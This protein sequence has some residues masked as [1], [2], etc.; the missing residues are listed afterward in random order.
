MKPRCVV[1]INVPTPYRQPMFEAMAL[2]GRVDL[3][4]IYC[5][6]AHIDPSNDGRSNQYGVHFLG[7]AY[8][9]QD[10]RF[11]HADLSVMRLLSELRPDVVVTTGFI[12]TFLFSYF[13]AKLHG[14]RHIAMTDGTLESEGGLSALHRIVRRFVFAGTHAFVGACK[15]SRDLYLSYG[16][17]AERIHLSA[18]CTLNERFQKSQ[19]EKVYDFLFC[20]RYLELKNPLFAISVAKKVAQKLGRKVTFRFVGKGPLEQAIREAGQACAE[21]VEVSFAG[22]LTQEE[23]PNEYAVSRLFLFPTSMDC[24]GVVLNEACAAGVPCITSPHTGAAGEIVIDGQS[25]FVCP[26]D[27]ALWVDRSVRLLSDAALWQAMSRESIKTI[28]NYT[29]ENAA[30]GLMDAVEQAVQGQR[31]S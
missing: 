1:V 22:Y 20:G 31:T 8:T 19:K 17:R 10:T 26:I 2:S 14:V 15:A 29:F 27:E 12:P 7:G 25:G 13:W 6:P 18:L 9:A 5:A 28:S 4:V 11:S 24:W 16:V 23:L 3:H 30:S 21:H